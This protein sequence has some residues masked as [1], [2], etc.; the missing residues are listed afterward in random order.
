MEVP[1]Y[2]VEFNEE[3]AKDVTEDLKNVYDESWKYS[4]KKVLKYKKLYKIYFCFGYTAF[5]EEFRY[6]TT[7]AG[8]KW[9]SKV[10]T[11]EREYHYGFEYWKHWLNTHNIVWDGKNIP[12]FIYTEEQAKKYLEKQ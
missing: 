5:G 1:N 2:Q 12:T 6:A 10:A 9:Y 3:E 8:V 7:I 11:L 4:I